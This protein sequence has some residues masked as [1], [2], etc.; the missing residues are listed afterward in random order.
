MKNS[1]RFFEN[2]D[3]EYFPC[4]EGIEEFNCMFCYCPMYERDKCP[5]NPEFIDIDGKKIKDCS[6]CIFPHEPKNYDVIM[7]LL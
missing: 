5:G 3:C 2:R 1:C 6:N 7:G 4:H